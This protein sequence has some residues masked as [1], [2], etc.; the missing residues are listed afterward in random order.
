MRW[1]WAKKEE[2]VRTPQLMEGQDSYVFR[3]SRTLTGTSSQNVQTSAPERGQ[4]KT[5]RLKLHEL[6]AHYNRMFRILLGI[7]AIIG[8][9]GWL[10]STFTFSPQLAAPQPGK[11][12]LNSEG[13]LY[14]YNAT[15]QAYYAEHPMERFGFLLNQSSFEQFARTKNPELDAVTVQRQWYG[16][17]LQL[18]LYFRQPLLVWQVGE[19]RFYVDG[20]GTVFHYNH[21]DEPV[22]SVTDQ[23][24]VAPAEDG[25]VASGRFIAFLGRMVGAVNT[26]RRG[27]VRQIVIPASTRQINL[28]LQGREYEIKT[29][30]DRDPLQQAE[31]IANALAYFDSKKIVPAYVDVRVP[32]KAFYK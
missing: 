20:E 32:H 31:D 30:I 15:V 27:E 1:P 4:L 26:Y 22:V 19:K 16:G 18:S 6:R 29:H 12:P 10:L 3:R 25:T 28:K 9:L 8:L 23:S 14:R 2:R 13:L 11:A 21:F 7:L 24:G 17:G 5:D